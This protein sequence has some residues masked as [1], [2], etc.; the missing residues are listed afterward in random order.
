MSPTRLVGRAGTMLEKFPAFMKASTPDKALAGIASALGGSLDESERLMTSIQRSHRLSVADHE[1]DILGLA[2]LMDLHLAD[3]WILRSLYEN[4][5]FVPP[6][7]AS[8]PAPTDQQDEEQAYRTY[9]AE[10]RD[11]VQR[12][13]AILL[14]GCGTIRA[15][16]DGAAILLDADRLNPDGDVDPKFSE[17]EHLDD[18][19]PRGG[20]LHRI[21]V[22]YHVIENGKPVDEKGYIYLIENPLVD[23][24]T[25]AV[26][27]RQRQQFR[28][29]RGG[30][31]DGPVSAEI[32]GVAGRTVKPL[33][34]NLSTHEGYG[35]R[36]V[37]SD[38]QKLVFTTDGT[39]LLDGADVTAEAFHFKGGLFD[40]SPLDP[41][42]AVDSSVVTRPAGALDRNFPRP[43]FTPEGSL[44][45]LNL[46]FGETDWRFSIEEGAFDASAFDRAVFK[47]P[48]DTA[49]LN[50]LPASGTVELKWKEQEPFA[51]SILLPAKVKTLQEAGIID[52]DINVLVRAGLEK[53]RAAGIRLDV[54]YYE[55]EWILGTSI[56]EKLNAA[57]GPGVHFGGTIPA[58]NEEE[59]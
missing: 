49:A 5:Y 36:N 27:R 23:R 15:L 20:F 33:V 35:Y 50:A 24:T 18:G 47:L 8:G 56:L 14:E 21:A 2:A 39:A 25:G 12:T 1:T 59:P 46:P 10:L 57:A 7:P 31:Y 19:L 37:L 22:A 40:R 16:L 9:L 11:L 6:P 44:P 43:A 29:R 17:V 45:P 42:E 38:G 55:D 28:A 26:E 51:V 48:T 41:S 3:F 13:V 30:F 34:I 53:F 58:D 32:T 52:Q 54:D 4:D